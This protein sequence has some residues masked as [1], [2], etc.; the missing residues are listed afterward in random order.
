VAGS[1]AG[2]A[3]VG[4]VVGVVVRPPPRWCRFVGLVVGAAA[5]LVGVDRTDVDGVPASATPMNGAWQPES[6]RVS[7]VPAA[8][9]AAARNRGVS[10]VML[11]LLPGLSEPFGACQ[12]R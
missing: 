9:I 8:A 11:C 7:A 3:G 12:E 5:V 10:V 6:A 1:P 4:V 2:G